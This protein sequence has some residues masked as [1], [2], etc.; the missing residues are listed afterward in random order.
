[1]GAGIELFLYKGGFYE[2]YTMKEAI[3]REEAMQRLEDYRA[4]RYTPD[5]NSQEAAFFKMKDAM[6]KMERERRRKESEG[7]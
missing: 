2:H 5:P 1:M 4:G 3:A 7:R 6:Y